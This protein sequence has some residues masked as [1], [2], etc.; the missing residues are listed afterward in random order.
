MCAAVLLLSS[1]A[2]CDPICCV[3]R[4]L[5]STEEQMRSLGLPM[6]SLFDLG[7]SA[8]ATVTTRSGSPQLLVCT[9]AGFGGSQMGT[10]PAEL[11]TVSGGVAGWAYGR[12]VVFGGG[13]GPIASASADAP[14]AAGRIVDAAA[15]TWA[16]VM[17]TGSVP[18]PVAWRLTGTGGA[19]LFESVESGMPVGWPVD[20]TTGASVVVR[21][22]RSQLL[23]FAA[24]A[25]GG[26]A[27][28]VAA[29]ATQTIDGQV[30]SATSG[31]WTY[32]FGSGQDGT[33]TKILARPAEARVDQPLA[34]DGTWLVAAP[35]NVPLDRVEWWLQDARGTLLYGTGGRPFAVFAR[36]GSAQAITVN[37]VT[38]NGDLMP[39]VAVAPGERRLV[40]GPELLHREN[41]GGPD[42][43]TTVD[44]VA[45]DASGREVARRADPL[46]GATLDTWTV[47][48]PVPLPSSSGA[49]G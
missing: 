36:N 33:I 10:W 9:P 19:T 34:G 39:L 49:G 13:Q 31:A 44:L 48:G 35:A 37:M 32:V 8:Q 3:D 7:D 16:V 25:Y 41:G 15:G 6:D 17:P 42:G 47:T 29:T 38:G 5:P 12:H 46:C 18:W 2:G 11:P 23:L 4:G 14:G 1:L 24:N 20:P 40:F 26:A 45:T 22:G 30:G 21:D 27:E 43:C 28:S